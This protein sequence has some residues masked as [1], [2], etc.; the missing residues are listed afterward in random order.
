MKYCVAC[1]NQM[2]DDAKFC[3]KCGRIIPRCPSCGKV[4]DQKVRFCVYD[5]TPLPEELTELLPEKVRQEGNL[6]KKKRRKW[7]PILASVMTLLLACTLVLGYILYD[8]GKV[9][10]W[11]NKIKSSEIEKNTEIQAIHI[12]GDDPS[13][14]SMFISY[15]IN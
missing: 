1:G 10:F 6:S 8:S 12:S 4:I 2:K 11:I 13:D 15:I 14:T 3:G 5:G 9:D 7:I